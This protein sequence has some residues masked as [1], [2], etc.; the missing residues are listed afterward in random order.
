MLVK[1]YRYFIYNM[2][3]QRI[4]VLS[5][6]SLAVVYWSSYRVEPTM[7]W[8]KSVLKHLYKF[9]MPMVYRILYVFSEKTL[10]MVCEI[11]KIATSDRW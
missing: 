3:V 2:F 7:A 10:T 1:F 8:F 11:Y 9:Y 4:S 5:D 6:R